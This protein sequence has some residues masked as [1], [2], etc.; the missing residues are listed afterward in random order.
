MKNFTIVL[1]TL[2]MVLFISSII[3]VPIVVLGQEGHEET[4]L[5][6]AKGDSISIGLKA[7]AAAMAVGLCAFATSRAQASIGAAG[8][9][10]IAEKP[11]TAGTIII[12]VAIPET[13]VILGFVV[14]AMI[15]LFL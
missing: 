14:A 3:V 2:F 8:V 15:I 7:F 12:L 1:T 5:E 9:G 10:A 6:T 11:E 13:L 4:A